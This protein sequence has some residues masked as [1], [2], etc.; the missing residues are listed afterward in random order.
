MYSDIDN[1]HAILLTREKTLPNISALMN[2]LME[3]DAKERVSKELLLEAIDDFEKD[4][5]DSRECISE[6]NAETG[7]AI[8]DVHPGKRGRSV[9]SRG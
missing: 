2:T 9:V 8:C 3:T 7:A 4:N 1:I 6:W 5:I